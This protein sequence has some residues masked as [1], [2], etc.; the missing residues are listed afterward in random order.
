MMERGHVHRLALPT[1]SS[2]S[3]CIII[4]RA[5]AFFTASERVCYDT[6]V[7]KAGG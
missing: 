1:L 3:V 6:C 2:V 5:S 7:Q 4:T